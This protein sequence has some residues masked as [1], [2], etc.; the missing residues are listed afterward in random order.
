M[1]PQFCG[2][3]IR[4]SHTAKAQQI[5]DRSGEGEEEEGE[6]EAYLKFVFR[7]Y[8]LGFAIC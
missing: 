6:G 4:L 1:Q 7:F 3:A 5:R 2:F 8:S